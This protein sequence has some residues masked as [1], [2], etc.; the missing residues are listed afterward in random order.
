MLLSAHEAT[1]MAIIPTSMQLC[2]AE[3][4][5]AKLFSG[6]DH[7]SWNR[8]V[9]QNIRPRLCFW[10]HE[11][12]QGCNPG[13]TTT[14]ATKHKDPCTKQKQQEEANKQLTVRNYMSKHIIQTRSTRSCLTPHSATL[15]NCRE[16]G[17]TG[18]HLELSEVGNAD[19]V[20]SEGDVEGV[21]NVIYQV[22]NWGLVGGVVLGNEAHEGK[23]GLWY[24][25][26]QTW[27]F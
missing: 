12:C 9:Q 19:A 24:G 22:V 11:P 25:H 2:Q 6:K 21:S 10:Q 4:A 20:G 5:N 7:C 1:R 27:H 26:I 18:T 8:S 15:T 17:H 14:L 23:H 13:V 16:N 3:Q